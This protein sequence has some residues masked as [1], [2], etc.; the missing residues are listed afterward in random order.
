MPVDKF[1]IGDFVEKIYTE[2]SLEKRF[3]IYAKYIEQLGFDAALYTYF[4]SSQLDSTKFPIPPIRLQ[5]RDFPVDFLEH[6]EA[7]HLDWNE[8]RQKHK[9]NIEKTKIIAVA[10]EDY[11]I[12]NGI[13]IPIMNRT[14]GAAGISIISSE[15]DIVFKKLKNE[16]FETLITCTQLFHDIN[17]SNGMLQ[18]EFVLY[19]LKI[20]STT[21]IEILRYLASGKHLKNIQDAKITSYKY[22]ANTLCTI[23]KKFGKITRDKLMYIVGLLDALDYR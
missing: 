19:F 10:K 23:R 15:T 6:Y 20:L 14:I 22:A 12:K 3:D 13:S 21:E 18:Q 5:T 8:Y 1:I 17:Y 16:K 7:E 4:P 2:Q 11:G 9:L